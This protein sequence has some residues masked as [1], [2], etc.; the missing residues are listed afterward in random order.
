MDKGSLDRILHEIRQW[1][2]DSFKS[3]H[4]ERAFLGN[5]ESSDD[6]LEEVILA[7]SRILLRL[8]QF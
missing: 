3:L 6:V 8:S 1:W 4:D 2:L 7:F 5:D